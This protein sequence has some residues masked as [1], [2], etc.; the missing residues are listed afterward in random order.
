MTPAE[1]T[2]N[3]QASPSGDTNNTVIAAYTPRPVSVGHIPRPSFFL[4][5]HS[6]VSEYGEDDDDSVIKAAYQLDPHD[7]TGGD[8]SERE[9]GDGQDDQQLPNVITATLPLP[10]KY[11][12]P[13][14]LLD[15]STMMAPKSSAPSAAL[16]GGK[17]PP[18]ATPAKTASSAAP[19]PMFSKGAKNPNLNAGAKKPVTFRKTVASSGYSANLPWSE[20]QRLKERAKRAAVAA[21]KNPPSA[22]FSKMYPVD[23]GYPETPKEKANAL[24]ADSK[25]HQG[26]VN[27]MCYDAEGKYLVTGSTDSTISMLKCPV[28][29]NNGATIVARGHKGLVVGVDVSLD[30]N[31]HPMIL[32]AGSDG[33]IGMWHPTRREHPFVMEHVT[34]KKPSASVCAAKYFYMDKLV[35]AGVGSSLQFY[36][37]VLDSGGGDLDRFRNWS[38]LENVGTYKTDAQSVTALDCI[39]SSLSTVVVWA[40]SNKEVGVVDVATESTIRRIDN[41]HDRPIHSLEMMSGSRY[42]S[43]SEDALH[44][45]ATSGFDSLTKIW[46]M[47]A[48]GNPSMVL[49]RHENW[50]IKVGMCFSPCGNFFVMGSQDCA[51]YVYD[52]R[53]VGDDS[54]GQ[55]ILSR[56]KTPDAVTACRFHPLNPTVALGTSGGDVRF[57][58]TAL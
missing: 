42:A 8:N 23:S 29:A 48:V 44:R 17:K 57:F 55:P 1:Q 6:D 7:G 40:G 39:N 50:G 13:L 51:A 20:Q 9:D 41:A 35:V 36:K 19:P 49:S 12:E 56:L 26:A 37:Y 47:R 33:H 5:A 24:L 28:V 38:R 54:G 43:V 15:P 2:P 31:A 11:L 18:L 53:M 3:R 14:K 45:F 58:G 25:V 30:T 32:S 21:K 22:A 27:S 46:D 4:P 34:A 10:P 16:G 52:L